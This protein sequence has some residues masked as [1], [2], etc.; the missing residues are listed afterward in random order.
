M[1]ALEP[2]TFLSATDSVASQLAPL[3]NVYEALKNSGKGSDDKDDD[4][5]DKEDKKDKDDAKPK[6]PRKNRGAPEITLLLNNAP[7]A[8]NSGNI[9]F[10]RVTVGDLGPVRTFTIRNDGNAPLTVSGLSLPAGFT[11]LDAPAGGIDAK[12]STTFTVRLDATAVGP[13]SGRLSFRTN[14]ADEAAFDFAVRGTIAAPPAPELTVLY[15]GRPVTSG[16]AINFGSATQGSDGVPRTLTIRNDGAAPL[17]VGR[18]R[19]P[20][21]FRLA[22]APGASLAPGESDT[23][24]VRMVAAATGDKT[25][26]LTFRTNDGNESSLSFPLTGSVKAKPATPPPPT[27]PAKPPVAT[28]PV[29]TVRL[30][31]RGRRSLGIDDGALS[32]IQFATTTRGATAPTRTFRIANEGTAALK[33]GAVQLP[34]GF[35]VVDGL[36]AT[37]APGQQDELVIALDT[38]TVAARSGQVTFTTN[39]ARAAVFNFAVAGTITAPPVRTAAVDRAGST[40]VVNGT[41]GDDTI[42][43][44]GRSSALSVTINGQPMAGTPFSGVTKMV[45]N[46]GA[47]DDAVNL[48]RLSLNATANGGPGNDTLTGT[49]ADDVL[50]GESGH[51]VLDGG[52]GTDN[53]LGGDGD[54]TLTGGPGADVFHGDAGADSLLA[55]DGIADA[56]LDT[57]DAKDLFKRDRVDPAAV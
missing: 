15:N 32:P 22:D 16:A 45:V 11:L 24:T 31:R 1:D 17:T 26:A 49:Q 53:L 47:G 54:D 43:L 55:A 36:P 3:A 18:I 39:D 46:A 29:V 33:L 28:A 37:L 21:G 52:P 5:D 10:G 8:D 48:A 14:D 13:K 7:V 41:S 35:R 20:A 9:D 38:S 4:D 6:K 40:L 50:N 23:L 44:S 2:R 34:A 30:I 56:L 57:G 51:D 19:L 27:P 42:V 12:D 25:G